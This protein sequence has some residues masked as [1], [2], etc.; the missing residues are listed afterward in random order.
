[1]V[2]I[3]ELE[4]FTGN[5]A[6]SSRIFVPRE[7]EYNFAARLVPSNESNGV[8]HLRVDNETFSISTP[9]NESKASWVELGSV[10]LD[11]GEHNVSVFASDSELS[12]DNVFKSNL[13]APSVSYEEVNPCKYV[14]HVNCTTPFL[15]VFSESY[16]PLWKA[17]VGNE[18]ISPIIVN[19]LANGFFINRT[20]NFD[21]V[22]Y[23]TG[24]DVA[25]IGLM[26]SGGSTILIIAVVLAKSTP[27]KKVSSFIRNRRSR[28]NS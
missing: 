16:S 22:L 2:S 28:K 24:Q 8:F 15:L 23:F 14:A 12:I 26:I 9:T 19:S 6:P 27:S 18:E 4:T 21:V 25:N 10:L 20:G 1:M 11:A 13:S 7:E 3:W 17:Y 5:E